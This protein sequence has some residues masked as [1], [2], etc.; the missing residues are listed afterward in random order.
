[1]KDNLKLFAYSFINNN[2]N[3]TLFLFH[4]TGGDKE[5]FFFLDGLLEKQYNLVGL[6]GNVN[7][8]GMNRFFKRFS[9]SVFDQKNISEEVNKLYYFIQEFKTSYPNL[10]E[11]TFFLGYSNGANILLAALFSFPSTFNTLILLHSML[12]FENEPQLLDLSSNK[13]FLSHGT[14]DPMVSISQQQT[15]TEVLESCKAQVFVHRYNS[16]H[17]LTTVELEDV[18][19]FLEEAA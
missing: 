5:D 16:G 7:E 13:I 17:Q 12:P 11:K 1:M 6:R 3:K 8:D 15:A 14:N 10:T 4:G 9:H 2:V 19:Q 18:K